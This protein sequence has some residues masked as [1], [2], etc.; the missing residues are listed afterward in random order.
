MTRLAEAL[1]R[2]WWTAEVALA[3][4]QVGLAEAIAS[5]CPHRT[6]EWSAAVR[7]L[8]REAGPQRFPWVPPTLEEI[9][10]TMQCHRPKLQRKRNV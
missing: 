3:H 9:L 10:E 8:R 2:V 4:A 7:D 1:V 6:R 5:Q